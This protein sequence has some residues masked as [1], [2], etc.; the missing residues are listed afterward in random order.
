MYVHEVNESEAVY[1]FFRVYRAG[2]NAHRE[3]L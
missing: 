2:E 3:V 1:E